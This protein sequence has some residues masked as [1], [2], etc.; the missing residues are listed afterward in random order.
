MMTPRL[1]A[2]LST[3]HVVPAFVVGFELTAG[4]AVELAQR[5]PQELT[6]FVQLHAH[7]YAGY[8]C[9]QVSLLGM[10]FRFEGNLDRPRGLFP[11]DALR[12]G[13]ISLGEFGHETVSRRSLHPE[14][15]WVGDLSPTHG[16]P[17]DEADRKLLEKTLLEAVPGLPPID[18]AVEAF[19]RFRAGVPKALLGWRGFT[20]SPEGPMVLDDW[21]FQEARVSDSLKV[22][23]SQVQAL[24]ALGEREKWGSLRTFLL[25][26]NSD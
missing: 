10:T 7:Q 12:R 22:T 4:R 24:Q 25:W 5:P 23:P 26:E 20:V 3:R 8:C 15:A 11:L 21:N 13:L 2:S 6:S 16:Q 17:Y 18:T 1:L 9:A 19:V 14:V